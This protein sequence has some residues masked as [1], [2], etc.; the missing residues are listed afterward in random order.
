MYGCVGKL[1]AFLVGVLVMIR[2]LLFGVYVG[3]PDL[4]NFHMCVPMH[5]NRKFVSIQTEMQMS[6]VN[7][8][9]EIQM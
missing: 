6:N 4:V 1:G 9:I 5:A 3:V 8:E 2:A 7:S